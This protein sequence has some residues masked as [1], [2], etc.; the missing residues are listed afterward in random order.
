MIQMR[1][2]FCSFLFLTLFA[3][4][5]FCE[6]VL[7]VEDAVERALS[8]NRGI[9]Q[10]SIIIADKERMIRNRWNIFLPE[11]T[12]TAGIGRDNEILRNS[13]DAAWDGRVGGSVSLTL[14]TDF[15]HKISRIKKEYEAGSIDYENARRNLE[16]AV[17]QS[18][19][20]L[21]IYKE[22]IAL[23][24]ENLDANRQRYEQAAEN[25]RAGLVPELDVLNARLAWTKLIP[26]F[27]ALETEYSRKLDLFK[28]SLGMDVSEKIVLSGDASTMVPAEIDFSKVPAEYETPALRSLRSALEISESSRKELQGS[29]LFPEL[30]LGWN[31][32]PVWPDVTVTDS[33]SDTGSF[34]ATLKWRLDNLIPY[35]MGDLKIEQLKDNSEKLRLQIAEETADSASAVE[36][37]IRKITSQL[38][39]VKTL[40]MTAGIAGQ[41]LRLTEDA[42]R[43]GVKD[44]LDVSEAQQVLHLA[45]LDILRQKYEIYCSLLELEYKLNLSFGTLGG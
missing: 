19:C 44:I 31:I 22:D 25:Y 17:R 8:E 43:Y 35:S 21:L 11:I 37:L 18:F 10:E 34:S 27:N 45:E 1:K 7:T 6:T 28:I 32:T 15:P 20:E 40:E 16:I 3:V 14:G 30:S 12:A 33:Y 5:A 24:K 38:E 36:N 26:D 4:P 13:P 39:T 9:K 2:I 23:V 29:S 41:T 42:Y